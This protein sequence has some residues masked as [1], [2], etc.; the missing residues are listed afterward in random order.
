MREKRDGKLFGARSEKDLKQQLA[1]IE[2]A[3]KAAV[4]QDRGQHQG[5]FYEVLSNN[6]FSYSCYNI[7]VYLCTVSLTI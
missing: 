6:F 7:V 3:A 2:K 1:D 5:M 4:A